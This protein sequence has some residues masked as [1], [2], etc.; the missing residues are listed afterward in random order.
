MVKGAYGER[1]IFTLKR[2]LN[3][4][5]VV[6]ITRSYYADDLRIRIPNKSLKY[7]TGN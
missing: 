4:D 5:F 2:H 6:D 1:F 3:I 7:N